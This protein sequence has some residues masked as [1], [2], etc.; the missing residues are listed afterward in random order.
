MDMYRPN[1]KHNDTKRF[2][3]LFWEESSDDDCINKHDAKEHHENCVKESY[4]PGP[5]R[6]RKAKNGASFRL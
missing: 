3:S 1:R 2:F 6:S 5:K 4:S